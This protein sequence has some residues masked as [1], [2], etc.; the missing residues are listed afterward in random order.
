MSSEVKVMGTLLK[1]IVKVKGF[2]GKTL[3]RLWEPC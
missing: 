2:P 3:W 1:P